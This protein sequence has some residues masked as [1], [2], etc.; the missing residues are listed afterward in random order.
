MDL[1]ND[2]QNM[3]AMMGMIGS[4]MAAMGRFAPTALD[5]GATL[6]FGGGAGGPGEGSASWAQP[7]FMQSAFHAPTP[8]PTPSPAPTNISL[9][10]DES[11]SPLAAADP[12][13]RPW[14]A[15][16]DG[17]HV[18][19]PPPGEVPPPEPI[20]PTP[21]PQ[22]PFLFPER[23]RRPLPGYVPPGGTPDE[24]AE[25]WHRHL[26]SL[27]S[28]PCRGICVDRRGRRSSAV[29]SASIGREPAD[30]PFDDVAGG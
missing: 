16:R 5:N 28:R 24:Y 9:A 8:T 15:L 20:W 22:A 19:R 11:A 23:P 18:F 6:T 13:P 21:G 3:Q 1:G 12:P 4:M 2:S 29:G 10:S 14:G 17:G 30:I 7:G 26:Y 27:T 25:W